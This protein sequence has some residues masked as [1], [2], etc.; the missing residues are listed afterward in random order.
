MT[1]PKNRSIYYNKLM[2]RR[3]HVGHA[4]I[5]G[6]EL[7]LKDGSFSTIGSGF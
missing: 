5:K 7:K 4:R 1:K 3:D 2:S 6:L